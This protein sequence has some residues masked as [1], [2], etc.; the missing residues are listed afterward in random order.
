MGLLLSTTNKLLLFVKLPRLYVI[1]MK[2]GLIYRLKG[3]FGGDG[4][5]LDI[6]YNHDYVTMNL[7]KL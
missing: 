4:Y 7:L 6:E 5:I 3:S 2:I 1:V